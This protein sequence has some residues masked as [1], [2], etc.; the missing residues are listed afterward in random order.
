MPKALHASVV[1]Q[2][3]AASARPVL[4]FELTLAESGTLR[5]AASQANV[6]WPTGG[7]TYTAKAV[8]VSNISRRAEGQIVRAVIR[9]DNVAKDMAAYAEAESFDGQAIS[10]KRVWRDALGSADYYNEILNGYMEEVVSIGRQW[11]EVK[12][13][14]GKSLQRQALGPLYQ[15][16]CNHRFGD[17]R[18]N[19]DG[20]A[21]LT[22][23][24]A[25]GTADS[26]SATTLVDDALTQADDYWNYGQIEITHGGVK[27]R[28][29]VKDFV[30][31]TD[32]VTFDV[33]LPVAVSNGDA[34]T[35]W[36]GCSQTWNACQANEAWGPSADNKANFLGF[37]HIGKAAGHP[38]GH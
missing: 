4:L 33:A 35:I 1:T 26:G 8:E 23:L 37:I 31:A 14:E 5:Y 17:G 21:D 3:D 13:V 34:Y 16:L 12:A 18:C 22:S 25:S 29:K 6:V 9:F 36:K 30:A 2:I 10:I 11:M 19:A 27:Y 7:N 20:Y 38:P 15:K 28:R 32:T 24:T